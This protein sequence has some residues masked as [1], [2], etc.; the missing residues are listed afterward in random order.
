M[1]SA[2]T[3]STLPRCH[4]KVKR[5][6]T[7]PVTYNFVLVRLWYD[8]R[9]DVRVRGKPS[10]SNL[11]GSKLRMAD[12]CSRRKFEASVSREGACVLEIRL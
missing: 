10:F 12:R 5:R 6:P 9:I 7:G 1:P 3:A 8:V 11:T 4:T 2:I